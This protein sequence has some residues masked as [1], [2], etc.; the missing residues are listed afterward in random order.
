MIRKVITHHGENCI[1]GAPCLLPASSTFTLRL[2]FL[3]SHEC[4]FLIMISQQEGA[5]SQT[6]YDNRRTF[7]IRQ[8]IQE[9]FGGECTMNDDM[10]LKRYGMTGD[11]DLIVILT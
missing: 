1:G 11:G 8:K 4:S 3:N 10:L 2:P 9:V 6:E 7:L 5:K